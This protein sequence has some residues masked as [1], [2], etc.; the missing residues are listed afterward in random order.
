M[1]DNK[2][3]KRGPLIAVLFAGVLMGALDISIIGPALPAMQ[4]SLAVY[5]WRIGELIGLL[6]GRI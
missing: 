4:A 1:T 2:V 6:W 5:T 3:I